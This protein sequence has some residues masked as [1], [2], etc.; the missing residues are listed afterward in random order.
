M[1]ITFARG[2]QQERLDEIL[3]YDLW[4]PFI[5]YLTFAVILSSKRRSQFQSIFVM[6]FAYACVGS[7]VIGLN[8]RLMRC[9][10]YDSRVLTF[11]SYLQ[12]ACILGYSSLPIIVAALLSFLTDAIS[13]IVTLTICLAAFAFSLKG[14]LRLVT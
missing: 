10:M 14:K 6:T 12:T 3:R 4:G 11:R 7:L 8:S 1:K 2:D 9:K 5:F 13:Y